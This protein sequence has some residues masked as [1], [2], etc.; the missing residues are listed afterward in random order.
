MYPPQARILFDGG[1][2]NKYERSLLEDNESPDCANVVFTNGAVE[3]RQ[4]VTKVNT[5]A[6]TALA[7]DGLYTRRAQDNSETMVAFA[8]GSMYQLVGTSFTT[9]PSAQSVFTIANRVG[10]A[11]YQNYLF[12]G[13]GGVTPYKW[14]GSAFTRHGVYAPPTSCTVASANA[15]G[16]LTASGQYQY[17]F[18][19]VNTALVE[20]DVG[21]ITS[22]F[23]ISTT[24]GQNTLSVIPTAPQSWGVNARNIYRNANGG[25]A[26]KRV[27][28]ISDNSTTTFT[29]NIADSSLGATAPTDNG[30]PPKYNAIIYHQNRLFMNDPSNPNYVWYSDITAAAPSPFGV[31]STN[32]FKVGD[33]TSDLV[34]GFG[35]YDNAVIVYCENSVWINY[36]P[37]A[38]PSNWKQIRA[39]SPH[40]SK[41]PYAIIDYNDK[42][43]FPAKQNTKFVGY[44]ALKGV[45][46][47]IT[48]SNF[49]FFAVGTETKSDRVEPDMFLIQES[50]LGR[51]SSIVFK[52]KAYLS[53]PYGSAATFNN[54]IYVYD[55]SLSNLRKDQEASW[56]PWTGLNAEQFTIYAGNLYF[57]TSDATGFV[58]KMESGVY[59]DNG[60][61]IDSYFW[62]KE[63]SGT[64]PEYNLQKD[65][66]YANILLENAGGFY[67]NIGYRTDSDSGSGNLN[68]V[69]LNP[70][71]NLWGTMRWGMDMWGGGS[72]QS[73]FRQ[74]LGPARGKRIQ[75]RFDNQNVSGQRFKVH[76]LNFLYNIKGYR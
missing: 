22:T 68:Q 40:G 74:F 21:P 3:T 8:G 43:L 61:A 62:T 59:S 36:M 72:G 42:Q 34:K 24:S 30:L 10:A 37:D 50:L 71:S 28:T 45:G 2:N 65:F 19:F 58:Y 76:G 56:V 23:I 69:N 4:G 38:T 66:R 14:D 31:P 52:N 1:K 5:A 63:F 26:F 44:G 73:E 11:Q 6:V 18:T 67:M 55:F 70:G 60:T 47:E 13:N 57:A 46:S 53:V 12:A 27:G 7:F 15:A 33:N 48:T 32:F 64:L 49:N 25:T 17:K 75:F 35:V 51:L 20:S 16:N 29:D 41:S 54:R 9:V 39:K